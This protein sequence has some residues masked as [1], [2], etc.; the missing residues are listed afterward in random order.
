[1]VVEHRREDDQS[2]ATRLGECF[3]NFVVPFRG[4]SPAVTNRIVDC[5]VTGV[6]LDRITGVACIRRRFPA[7]AISYN[8]SSRRR[9]FTNSKHVHFTSV[10]S[11]VFEQSRTAP[12]TIV[13]NQKQE[14]RL[15][16]T[17]HSEIASAAECWMHIAHMLSLESESVC[18]LY[19]LNIFVSTYIFFIVLREG[20]HTNITRHTHKLHTTTT[21]LLLFIKRK[22]KKKEEKHEFGQ[23]IQTT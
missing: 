12:Q 5:I 7:D 1:M 18:S 23:I 17:P 4:P 13:S 9:T 20:L 2:R 14:L 3:A 6:F 8:S 22:K 19:L 11:I 21:E 15:C 16:L 10:Y